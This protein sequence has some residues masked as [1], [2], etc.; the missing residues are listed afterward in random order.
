MHGDETELEAAGE[1]AEHQQDVGSV[2]EA[3]ASAC[4]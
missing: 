2:T 1:E 4:L 3:S